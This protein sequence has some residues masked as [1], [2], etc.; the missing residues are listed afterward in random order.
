M[1]ERINLKKLEPA[2]Y[3]VMDLAEKTMAEFGLDMPLLEL[4]KLRASQ[5]NGCGYCVDLHAR[6]ALQAGVPERKVFAVA[7]WWETPF[8][9]EMER[10]ALKM[11]EEITLISRDGLTEETFQ[12]A[13]KYFNE[14]QLAQLIFT[15]TVTN[16]WNR[17]AVSSHMV[18]R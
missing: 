2:I 13:L 7:V 14:K 9:T 4:M 15:V 11:T 12:K 17:L 6:E 3:Q 5:L 8:F 16:N 18:I 1:K 10:C